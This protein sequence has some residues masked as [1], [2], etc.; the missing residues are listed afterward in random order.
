MVLAFEVRDPIKSHGHWF[1]VH[2]TAT[3]YENVLILLPVK[4]STA[5]K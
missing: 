3:P 2:S 5:K 4:L 1:V